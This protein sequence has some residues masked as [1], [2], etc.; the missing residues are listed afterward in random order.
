MHEQI[1]WPNVEYAL[2]NISGEAMVRSLA[3]TDEDAH[4]VAR[5]AAH[6]REILKGSSV[7]WI[8]DP[9]KIL[10]KLQN[11]DFAGF[12]MFFQNKMVASVFALAH[13]NNLTIEAAIIIAD[14]YFDIFHAALAL[15]Q[16]FANICDQTPAHLFFADTV[17]VHRGSQ[18][19]MESIGGIPIGILPLFEKFGEP[20]GPITNDTLVRYIRFP[21]NDPTLWLNEIKARKLT[22]D[23]QKLLEP[24]LMALHARLEGELKDNLQHQFKEQQEQIQKEQLK[25]LEQLNNRKA[26]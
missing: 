18:K 24:I 8:L 9:E 7:A 15:A 17:T 21:K 4:D 19:L 10:E 16:E 3:R 11:R 26:G 6:S 5:V 13:Q 14:P 1:I 22:P 12:G 25:Q 20:P 2:P 23:A